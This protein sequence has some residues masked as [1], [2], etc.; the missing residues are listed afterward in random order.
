MIDPWAKQDVYVDI[1]NVE[2]VEQEKRMAT[3]AAAVA[4]YAPKPVLMRNF[5]F[6]A[7]KRFDDCS[8]DFVYID[9][10][11]DC[12]RGGP[13]RVRPTQRAG[14]RGSTRPISPL[15]PSPRLGRITR[16]D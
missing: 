13:P 1:A 7:V 14:A 11:H 10:V 3:A 5:S 15:P 8:L 6:D 16:H 9:A 4:K 2:T 12:A